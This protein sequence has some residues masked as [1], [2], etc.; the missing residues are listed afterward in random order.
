MGVGSEY[1]SSPSAVRI[2][3]FKLSSEKSIKMPFFCESC[4]LPCI[5]FA[6]AE[7]IAEKT[8]DTE[9]TSLFPPHESY[10]DY[11]ITL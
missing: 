11:F 7:R 5:L 4:C 1:P 9:K 2:C 6:A 10:P 3:S 8:Y